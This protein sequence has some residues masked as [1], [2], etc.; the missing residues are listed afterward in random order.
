MDRRFS[1]AV[2]VPVLVL[3]C[4]GMSLACKSKPSAERP[5]TEP[6][7][8]AT[9]VTPAE[10]VD[11]GNGFRQAEPIGETVV[12]TSAS[13]AE[14]LNARGVLKPIHYDFDKYDLKSESIRT[15]GENAARIKDHSQFDVRVEG[16]C[17]ERGTLE[18]NLALGEK[19]ARAARDYLIS[20]GVPAR[21][22]SIISYG[23]ERP[24]NNGH[25][26]RAWAQN[27]RSAFIFLAE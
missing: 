6:P 7:S 23:K 8:F 3:V 13:M 18:Y 20:L 15:L 25:N 11:E 2:L 9:P 17:D 10:P 4:V 24:L 16:H 19:R 26:E 5:V 1:R 12:E 27:R 14:K 21:R 22:L